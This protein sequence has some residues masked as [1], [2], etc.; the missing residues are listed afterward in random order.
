MPNTESW[1][2]PGSL[3]SSEES[4]VI[5]AIRHIDAATTPH[6]LHPQARGVFGRPHRNRL[7]PNGDSLPG[8][9]GSGGYMEYDVAPPAGV[10]TRGPRRIVRETATGKLY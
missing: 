2:M 10:V 8:I 7:T 5:N 6:W 4:D 1:L 9:P 3:P